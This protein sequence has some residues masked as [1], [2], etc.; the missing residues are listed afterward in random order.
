MTRR[1]SVL[2]TAFVAGWSVSI[3][4]QATKPVEIS[5]PVTT[6]E[7]AHLR[8][9]AGASVA[10]IAPGTQFT[11]VFDVTPLRNIHVYAPGKHG[12]QVVNVEVASRPW[13]RVKATSYPPST[14]YHFKPLDERVAVY[15]KPFQLVREVAIPGTPEVRKAL[16]GRTTVTLDA[17]LAYQACDDKICYSPEIVPLSWTLAVK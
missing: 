15:S 13:L 10:A 11:L 5:G 4:G 1:F 17:T 3:G 9:N 6:A 2:L 7:T 12:Y 16:T 8:V 14:I